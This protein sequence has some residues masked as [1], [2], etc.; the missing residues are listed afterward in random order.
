[1]TG[2]PVL[3]SAV[4]LEPRAHEELTGLAYIFWAP[5]GWGWFT[6]EKVEA[7]PLDTRLRSMSRF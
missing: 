3:A 6:V 1:M 7:F 2:Y 5:A 4:L